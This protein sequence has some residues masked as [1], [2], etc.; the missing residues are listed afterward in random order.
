MQM[1]SKAVLHI[2]HASSDCS[3]RRF[4]SALLKA[5]KVSE[6]LPHATTNAYLMELSYVNSCTDGW[7][8][9]QSERPKCLCHRSQPHMPDTQP[10]LTVRRSVSILSQCICANNGV[11]WRPQLNLAMEHLTR[12]RSDAKLSTRCH[13]ILRLRCLGTAS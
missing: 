9:V 7:M 6:A 1:Y 12:N 3:I 5:F 13:W 2:L 4:G 11:I 10:Q 8:V